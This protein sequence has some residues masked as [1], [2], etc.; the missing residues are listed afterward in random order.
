[1]ISPHVNIEPSGPRNLLQL[2]LWTWRPPQ[3]IKS[4]HN[5]QHSRQRSPTRLPAQTGVRPQAV[6]DI[7]IHRPVDPDC[8]RFWE[9]FGFAIRADEAAEDFVSGL[10]LD[11]PASVIDGR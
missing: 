6:V 10:D 9:E 4:T 7:S 2:P 5:P 1:M 3:V 11:R 8:V